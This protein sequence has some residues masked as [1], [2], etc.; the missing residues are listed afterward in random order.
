MYYSLTLQRLF[1]HLIN[2]CSVLGLQRS[3]INAYTYLFFFF[4]FAPTDLSLKTCFRA[5][6]TEQKKKGILNLVL[7]YAFFI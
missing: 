7:N 1:T 2:V 3:D 6:Y 5:K 4:D